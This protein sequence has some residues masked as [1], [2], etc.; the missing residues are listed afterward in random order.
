MS[1]TGKFTLRLVIYGA[2]LLYL[3]G[4]LFVWHGFLAGRMDAYLKPLP[5][6]PGDS[7][8]RIAEVYGEP[9]TAN[10]LSRRI[11]ELK[12]LR[13]PPVLDMEG[14]IKLTHEPDIPGDLAPRARYDLIGSSLLR[15][16]TSVNDLQLPNRNAE[17]ARA[18]EQIRSRF[19]GDTEQYLKTLH[20]QKL[21]QE[22]FQ[23]KIAARL[24]QTEQ[25]YR[26]TAQAAEASDED[27]KTCYN[28]IR[29]Q[30]TP[31]DLR[32]TRHIFL[33]TLNREEAQVRQ[34]AETLLERLKAGESFSRLAREFSEDERSA[35]AGGELGWINPA[36]AKETLGLALADVPDDK[37]VL[38][39]SRWGWHLV[40]ASP[41]KK[42]KTPSYEEALPALRDAT[43][44]LRKAQ[45]VGLYMD[46][47]F[48]EAHL[49]NRIKNK[50]GR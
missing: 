47:L 22:Q 42:G 8:A 40:E 34:T 27:L 32:K 44:S 4:D 20:G 26:A 33:A 24:K 38:L 29:D 31:P 14:G 9:V 17:A 25:L 6:P 12:M 7:S 50:Q 19:D 36:R 11:T 28:L 49:R 21:T 18:V 39:K 43:R 41:V 10:Q 15:L 3:V 2:F 35:P 13:Q 37:P 23:K 48:E 1:P 16:K 45:A 5:G 30:L 46:G